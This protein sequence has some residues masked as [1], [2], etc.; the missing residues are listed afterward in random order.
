MDFSKAVV[1][2]NGYIFIQDGDAITSIPNNLD[3]PDYQAYLAY[4]SSLEA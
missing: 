2:E 1:Q 4:L 3:N